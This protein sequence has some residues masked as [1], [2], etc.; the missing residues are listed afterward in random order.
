VGRKPGVLALVVAGGLAAVLAFAT[1]AAGAGLTAAPTSVPTAARTAPAAA[2]DADWIVIAQRAD[3][4]IAN[5]PGGDTVN[6]YLANFAAQGLARATTASGTATYASASW[7]WLEW[8]QA[9]MNASG[10]VTDYRITNGAL[11]STN[12]MDSTDSYAGTFLSA[13]NE[14]FGATGD[15]GQLRSLAPG[16]AKAVGAI[17]AT[18]D[19]DG[20][21]WAKPSYHVKYLMDQAEAYAG[22]QA[23]G[24]IAGVLGDA[25]LQQRA[26]N[27]A[28]RIA[29]G[30]AALWNARTASYDWAVHSDG[31]HSATDWTVLY[32]DSLQQVW[33][34]AFGLTDPTRG[35]AL[36]AH[37][38]SSQPTY[39]QPTAQAKYAGGT[40]PVGYWVPIGWA[41]AR[42]GQGAAAFAYAA[43]IRAAAQAV[44]RAW[45]FTPGDS[46]QLVVL[47]NWSAPRRAVRAPAP[48]RVS[49]PTAP[50]APT[51]SPPARPAPLV[52]LGPA[53]S[54][55]GQVTQKLPVRP[56]PLP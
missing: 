33:A 29:N 35:A 17:E 26:L 30:V 4:A 54:I 47:D 43:A 36:M 2:S 31:T 7:R 10:F 12:D 19:R 39:A 34:V 55:V 53:K 32:P 24:T 8:Y 9:H 3:G 27:D 16:I 11:A 48:T 42:L 23:A 49:P 52:D 28:A 56:P 20:L 18:Q 50:A 38:T 15:I 22:L 6:P 5:Y 25:G 44:G 1:P 46:G 13:V 40:R 21:T 41:F 51:T 37:F 45:P 14:T